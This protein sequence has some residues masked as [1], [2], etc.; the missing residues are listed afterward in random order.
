MKSAR[1]SVRRKGGFTLIELLVVIAIIAILAAMLL[2]VLA[3]AKKKAH[4]AQCLSNLRQWGISWYNYTEDHNGSFSS[5]D[6]VNWERGEWAEALRV[7]YRKKPYL[8]LCPTA[9]SRRGAPASGPQEAIVSVDDSTAVNNG[10]PNTAYM[11]P[12]TDPEAPAS[13]PNRKLIGSYGANCW[14]YDP[15]ASLGDLQNRPTSYNFRKIHRASHPSDS[16]LMV[17]CMWRGGGPYTTKAAA[18]R[19]PDYNGHWIG[20]GNEMM[21]FAMH[22][23]GK[24]VQV[25][26]FDGSVRHRR[27]RDL[28]SLYWH[29]QF[30]IN[31]A[32]NQSPTFFPAWMR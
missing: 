13:K 2:P 3:K 15:P 8:L 20:S 21:H 23:H 30:D 16:P 28:W 1:R 19:P 22:R 26:M 10:G 11:F 25:G 7:Y 31:Y 5:G 12:E 32:A 9:S 27:A 4:A 14:I 18:I 29:T 17:D 6:S 24:G